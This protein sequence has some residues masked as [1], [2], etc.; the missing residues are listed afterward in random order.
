M[1]GSTQRRG[2]GSALSA[3]AAAGPLLRSVMQKVSQL[4]H[5]IGAACQE[6][7]HALAYLTSL[8][9]KPHKGVDDLVKKG[10]GQHTEAEVEDEEEVEEEGEENEAIYSVVEYGACVNDV[11]D[12]S[13]E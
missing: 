5:N 11:E 13:Q 1:I 2:A 9:A 7:V 10:K 8:A 4:E 12:S 6:N 3:A